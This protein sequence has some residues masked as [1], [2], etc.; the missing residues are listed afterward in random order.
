MTIL[1][2]VRVRAPGNI[3]LRYG[4]IDGCRFGINVDGGSMVVV[5]AVAPR[6]LSQ[7]SV[8]IRCELRK[9][10]HQ[11]NQIPELVI[12]MRGP[13]GWHSGHT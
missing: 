9:S 7:R 2:V 11:Y 13:P 1:C 3:T 10:L 12:V 5:M 6:A 4:G 8:P